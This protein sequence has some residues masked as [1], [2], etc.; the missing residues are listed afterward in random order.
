MLSFLT[1][2]I[3]VFTLDLANF[4][5]ESGTVVNFSLFYAAKTDRT[6]PEDGLQRDRVSHNT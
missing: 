6:Q 5:D 4:I 2:R 3:S 1:V